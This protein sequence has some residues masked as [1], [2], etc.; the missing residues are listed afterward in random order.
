MLQIL[1]KNSK[2]LSY[3]LLSFLL[4][5][6][7][8]NHSA[9]ELR[10]IANTATSYYTA[11][12]VEFRPATNV[13]NLLEENLA[14]YLDIIASVEAA[15]T[16]IIVFPE[17]TLNSKPTST[18]V[19][20]PSTSDSDPELVPCLLGNTS[21]YAEFLVQI[22]CSAR[23]SRKYL[24]INLTEREHCTE[25]SEDPRP[26]ASDGLNIYNT[27]VVFD[28]E[29]R[30]ISRYR[31]WNLFSEPKNTTNSVELAFFDTDFGVRFGHFICF[32]ILFYEPGQLLVNLGIT[33]FVFPTMWFS[34]LPFLTSVQFQQSWSYAND[35]N[36]LA[37]GASQPAVGS[38]GTAIFA[39][40]KG[41][42]I[43]VMNKGEGE[44]RLY[45]AKV[46]KKKQRQQSVQALQLQ[47]SSFAATSRQ[48]RI[49]EEDIRLKRDY[50]ELYE[51]EV[52]DLSNAPVPLKR[53]LCY[54]TFC[55]HFELQWHPLFNSSTMSDYYAYRLGAYEG[56]RKEEG[57]DGTNALRNCAVFAC[58]GADIADCGKT[59]PAV[60]VQQQYAFDRI[61][62]EADFEMNSP[63]LVMPNSLR[64]DLLPL[65]VN[66]F[67]WEESK[68]A[69][70]CNAEPL[71]FRY[72]W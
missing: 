9:L 43:S 33:D 35:V 72:L 19:P 70:Y 11:G 17:S 18:F 4:F 68:S 57:A 66:E 2:V 24:V 23:Q 46:L 60:I 40:R 39:G 49:S 7:S 32:D 31:K 65:N 16:D 44:R 27:N 22:S 8:T 1:P 59:L 48:S 64:D 34:Q 14:A 47:R 36:F 37:A 67:V 28:R 56:I 42:L 53:D 50:L 54:K 38:T 58:V 61:M 71:D 13:S 20:N 63:A 29:G 10:S 3:F 12:V 45:V 21:I 62:I 69:E 30:V 55:C 51:S 5:L 15:N 25:T 6:D 41:A 26:C 52:L